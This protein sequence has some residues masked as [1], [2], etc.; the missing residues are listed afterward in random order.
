MLILNEKNIA[1]LVE[2][3]ELS[4]VII[5]AMKAYASGDYQMPDRMH[6]DIGKNTL[7]LMPAA[8]GGSFATKLVSLFPDNPLQGKPVLYGTVILN[9]GNTGEPLALLNGAKLTAVRTAA[10][11]ASGVRF[12]SPKSA[13][14]LGLIGAGVQGWHQILFV[15]K[16]RPI[17]DVYIYDPFLKNIDSFVNSLKSILPDVSFHSV[18]SSH[19]VCKHSEIVVTATNSEAP[20]LPDDKSLL[21]GKNF[22]AIGSYKENMLEIPNAIY[23]LVDSV[24]IDVEM[25]IE[26]SGDLILPLRN[27]LLSR[28]R[29]KLLSDTFDTPPQQN[30]G[31]T[32]LFK[33][34]GMALFDL[35]T[36]SYLF[37]EAGKKGVGQVVNL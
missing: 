4:N 5:D 16:I 14:T 8:C 9:D 35:F 20:V 22:I 23:K 10:V 13:H 32:T 1:E 27:G 36:A 2:P 11:G 26:E 15:S 29:I 19:E 3:I 24:Y 17:S 30:A 6:L 28:D 33:S 34:V 12:L 7:L 31:N 25:A 21:R 37:E 18:A